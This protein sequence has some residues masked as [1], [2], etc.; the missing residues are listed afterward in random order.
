MIPAPHSMLDSRGM[1]STPE[2][3]PK[4]FDTRPSSDATD[5]LATQSLAVLAAAAEA[6]FDDPRIELERTVLLAVMLD[7]G[8]ELERT[9]NAWLRQTLSEYRGSRSA[10][11][12][13][14]TSA[15]LRLALARFE[16]TVESTAAQLYRLVADAA[17]KPAI[18]QEM[19]ARAATA[20]RALRERSVDDSREPTRY[21]VSA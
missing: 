11:D 9:L 5:R 14:G 7:A 6:R 16:A 20:R 17:D 8:R 13:R 18:D 10:W 15:E 12:L 3:K 21:E 1:A 19:P 4:S 2:D